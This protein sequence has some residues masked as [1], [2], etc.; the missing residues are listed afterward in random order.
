MGPGAQWLG[1][2]ACR[3][4]IPDGVHLFGYMLQI[5]EASVPL[6]HEKGDLKEQG[7]TQ[8]GEEGLQLR[9]PTRFQ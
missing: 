2:L 6:K 4:R 9:P 7:H 5:L 1:A 3:P 8:G